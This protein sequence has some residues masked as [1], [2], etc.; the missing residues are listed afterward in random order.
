MI[1]AAVSAFSDLAGIV[2]GSINLPIGTDDFVRIWDNIRKNFG[3]VASKALINAMGAWLASG[4]VGG[5][6]I[7]QTRL[8]TFIQ[9]H[10]EE[11]EDIASNVLAWFLTT[12]YGTTLEVAT[13]LLTGQG[14]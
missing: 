7:Q 11:W 3:P 2:A 6:L 13:E 4:A 1:A 5:N 9:K 14:E 8:S 10:A 12:C